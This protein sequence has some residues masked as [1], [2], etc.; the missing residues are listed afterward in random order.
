[1]DQPQSGNVPTLESNLDQLLQ[2]L[3]QLAT[4]VN[5]PDIHQQRDE[6]QNGSGQYYVAT[7]RS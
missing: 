2:E 5:Q 4:R 1:M 3:H 7:G 6:S